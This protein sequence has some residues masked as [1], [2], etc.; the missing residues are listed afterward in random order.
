MAHIFC[1][2]KVDIQDIKLKNNYIT[3]PAE[4][5]PITSQVFIK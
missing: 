2:S 1:V 3:P 5:L 4:T